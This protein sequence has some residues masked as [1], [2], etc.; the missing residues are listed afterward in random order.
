MKRGYIRE[1]GMIFMRMLKGMPL[2]VTAEQYKNREDSRKR[3]VRKCMKMYKEIRTDIKSFGEYDHRKNLYFIGISTSGKEVWRNKVFYENAIEKI[4]RNK[5]K[6]NERCKQLPKTDLKFGSPHPEKLGLYVINKIG[7]KCIF[8]NLKKLESRRESISR[9]YRKRHFKSK[10]RRDQA[11]LGI[12]RK[13]R[14]QTRLEDGKIFFSYNRVGKEI[15]I[16]EA[17]YHEKRNKE[18]EKRRLYH[19]EKRQK[20]CQ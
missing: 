19:I 16:D 7:N 3:Y 9:I 1:D 14:G 2:W 15:W 8:G 10:K 20:K 4:K 18:L 6:Y 5:K 12:E 17:V 11:L 13:K